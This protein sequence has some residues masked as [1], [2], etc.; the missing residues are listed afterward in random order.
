MGI[1]PRIL[2]DNV[3]AFMPREREEELAALTQ[4]EFNRVLREGGVPQS[5]H[6]SIDYEVAKSLTFQ[7]QLMRDKELYA[8]LVGWACEYTGI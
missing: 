8:K 1:S 3:P 6:K 2:S 5:T 4:K 7:G